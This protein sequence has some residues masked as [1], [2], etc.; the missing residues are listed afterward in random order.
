MPRARHPRPA[1][2]Y[3]R[4]M[5]TREPYDVVLV[6]CEGRKTEPNYIKGLRLAYGLSSVNVRVLEPPGQDPLSIVRFAIEELDRDQEYD[7]A[8]CVFDRDGHANFDAAVRLARESKYSIANKLFAITSIPC[9]E[10]WVLLH[11]CY[12]TAAYAAAGGLS[13]C[14]RVVRDVRRHC[15]NYTKASELIFSEL[16][17]NVSQAMRNAQRLERH[18]ADTQTS[19][20]ATRVHHLVDYL[21]NLKT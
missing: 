20:P 16:A 19:N 18:N 4:G 2:E 21:V 6:A 10:L 17:G 8:Y 9:F 15:P 1:A 5:P 7:R 12:S 13:A 11:Y 3:R 14:E